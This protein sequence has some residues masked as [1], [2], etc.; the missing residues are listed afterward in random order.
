MQIKVVTIFATYL[1]CLKES[2]CLII[3]AMGHNCEPSPL[4]DFGL[5]H[6]S[7]LFMPI[8]LNK[9]FDLVS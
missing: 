8:H 6:L 1:L 4:I 5:K 2:Q 7:T 9:V 3:Y